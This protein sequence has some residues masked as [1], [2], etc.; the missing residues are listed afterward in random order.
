[1]SALI[2]EVSKRLNASPKEAPN[3]F[4]L[5]GWPYG[6]TPGGVITNSVLLSTRKSV[7]F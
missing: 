1:V 2:R 3:N 7:E 5:V 4:S 6:D